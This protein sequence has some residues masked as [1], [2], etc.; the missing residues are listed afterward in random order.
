MPNLVDEATVQ[1]SLPALAWDS[2]Q[3]RRQQWVG[4]PSP[5]LTQAFDGRDGGT[6]VLLVDDDGRSSR[7]Q[8][9]FDSEEAVETAAVEELDEFMRRHG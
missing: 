8:P 4:G 2:F 6:E 3:W 5:E 7:P 9:T 1:K